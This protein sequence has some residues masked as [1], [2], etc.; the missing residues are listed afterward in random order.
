MGLAPGELVSTA[1]TGVGC[2]LKL[3]SYNE[4]IFEERQ[5]DVAH[6]VFLD[7]PGQVN[8]YKFT[9]P[10]PLSLLKKLGTDFSLHNLILEDI[11]S[12]DQRPKVDFL[13]GTVFVVVRLPQ[14]HSGNSGLEL[15]QISLI[16]TKN[17]VWSFQERPSPVF[18][19]IVERICHHKGKLREKKADYLLYS[20]LDAVV[21]HYYPLLETMGEIIEGLELK[22]EMEK[23][24]S[25]RILHPINQLK[26][27]LIFL[28]KTVLPLQELITNLIQEESDI[29]D[30]STDKY[31]RDLYDHTKQISDTINIYREIISHILEVH[32]AIV[33]NRLNE[34]MKALTVVSFIFIPLTF[35]VGVYGM[36]FKYMPELSWKWGYAG[37]WAVMLV[38]VGLSVVYFKKKKWF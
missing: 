28:R 22:V 34:V 37:V 5:L 32:M 6:P 19:V 27:D 31:L 38:S 11:L 21:D 26:R 1:E 4:K 29:L 8:W 13:E 9:G 20:L 7:K 12:T 14:Y 36:N 16:L 2:D 30:A 23:G 35:F 3:I 18:D 10:T 25:N 33:N 15:N 24:N 17:T